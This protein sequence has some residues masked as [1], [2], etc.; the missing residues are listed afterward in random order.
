M[1]LKNSLVHEAFP[2]CSALS[3]VVYGVVRSARKPEGRFNVLTNRLQP[4]VVSPEN[5]II[6]C[7]VFF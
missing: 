6:S 2:R 7:L 1:L 3:R 4:A 5:K